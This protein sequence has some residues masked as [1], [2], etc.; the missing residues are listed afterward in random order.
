MKDVV[1]YCPDLEAL[2]A[3]L[4]ELGSVDDEG[5]AIL[6]LTRTPIQYAAKG[7]Q[8]LA[9]CRF[10]DESEITAL[11]HLQNLELLGT[12]EE[13]FASP[14]LMAKYTSVY[15]LS[16]I[17]TTDEN[18]EEVTYQPPEKFGVFA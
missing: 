1:T 10:M 12:Y 11:N 15:D 5:N 7:S 3:E 14:E 16:P 8:S 9:L 2:K 4:V 13:V 6:P 18:G 17:T